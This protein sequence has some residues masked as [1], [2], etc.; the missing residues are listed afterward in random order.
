MSTPIVALALAVCLGVLSAAGADTTTAVVSRDRAAA[1]AQL[2]ATAVV[3]SCGDREGCA[4][5]PACA[6]PGCDVCRVGTV[7]RAVVEVD[8]DTVLLH[9]LAPARGTHLVDLG[10]V[11]ESALRA[12][13]SCRRG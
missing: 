5:A 4:P 1:Q 3:E 11:G 7:L 6:A 12:V 8:F 10:L 2:V 9:G 13:P